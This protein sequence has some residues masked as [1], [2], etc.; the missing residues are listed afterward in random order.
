MSKKVEIELYPDLLTESCVYG[1]LKDDIIYIPINLPKDG[2]WLEIKK[3]QFSIP[4]D[5]FGNYVNHKFLSNEKGYNALNDAVSKF[6]EKYPT[7]NIG[8]LCQNEADVCLLIQKRVLKNNIVK[9]YYLTKITYYP[10]CI[11]VGDYE[12]WNV[13]DDLVLYEDFY[14]M[15]QEQIE[16]IAKEAYNEAGGSSSSIDWICQPMPT[17]PDTLRR[18]EALKKRTLENSLPPETDEQKL[19]RWKSMFDES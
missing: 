11:N 13:C 17:D 16:A 6:K 2:Y 5:R 8:I 15:T 9:Y 4:L 12:D 19:K 14:G 18:I 10:G 3:K 7:C 1:V